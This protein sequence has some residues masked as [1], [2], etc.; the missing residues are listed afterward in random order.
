[1]RRP[2]VFLATAACLLSFSYPAHAA[3]PAQTME[4]SGGSAFLD[5]VTAAQNF[6][7]WV[8]S[9]AG[10]LNDWLGIAGEFGGSYA[11]ATVSG[12]SYS[13]TEVSFMGGP[14]FAL[15]KNTKVTPFVQVLL[16][17][18]HTSSGGAA[19]FGA[20]GASF[21]A[22]PGGGVD[23]NMTSNF[24]LR[25]EAD[26]RRVHQSIGNAGAGAPAPPTSTLGGGGTGT[27]DNNRRFL[28]AVVFRK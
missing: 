25:V 19:F 16:G 10:Y 27:T 28:I 9:V 23:V 17:G 13:L 2:L 1:M 14:K 11:T 5:D 21:A 12:T 7:G 3:D 24:G 22:Q 26:Y 8:A 15:H 6:K 20:P 4:I 18:V